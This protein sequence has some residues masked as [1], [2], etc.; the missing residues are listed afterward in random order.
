MAAL[1]T[2]FTVSSVFKA[3][4]V[5]NLKENRGKSRKHRKKIYKNIKE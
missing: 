3:C 4:T 5:F 2:V 1:L